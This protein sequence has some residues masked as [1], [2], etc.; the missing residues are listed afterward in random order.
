MESEPLGPSYREDLAALRIVAKNGPSRDLADLLIPE[1]A[2][3]TRPGTQAE[4]TAAA[5][6]GTGVVPKRR[7]GRSMPPV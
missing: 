4:P 2:K 1:P 3:V 6:A 7:D 5:S